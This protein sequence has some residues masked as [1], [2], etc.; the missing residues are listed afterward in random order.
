MYSSDK[1][2]KIFSGT[3]NFDL[4]RSI[5]NI[6]DIPVSE[7]KIQRFSDGELSIQIAEVVRGYDVFLVQST[8][9]P[10]NEH[11][12][13]LL[14]MV[15]ALK[16]AS[17][18]RITVVIPYFGYARQDRKVKSRESISAKLVANII[19]SA[20]ADRILTMDL[21][22]PQI[23]GFFDIPLDHL[24][25]IVLFQKYFESLVAYNP[26]DFIIVSPDFGGVTRAQLLADRL[27]TTVAVVNKRRPKP[28]VSEVVNIIGQVE[29]K[30]AI[31]IDDIIDTAGT[32]VNATEAIMD[33]GALEIFGAATH[34]VLSGSALQ[35]IK[36]SSL[37]ELI[38]LDTIKP[39]IKYDES[40]KIKVISVAEIFAEA[41]NRIHNNN[42]MS[43]LFDTSHN[44]EFRK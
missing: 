41:I 6:L 20:G 43:N 24:F 18:G 42:S 3:S 11:L 10:V 12:M 16:R 2:L 26:D 29:N 23:Q 19:T 9:N 22:A 30:R 44:H 37:K 27:K 13:E 21:H 5:A 15:D 28:N 32:F 38:V 31:L 33:S 34:P 36:C 1:G 17:A 25:G 4:T 8:S 14:I 35:K 7:T 39:K 40:N